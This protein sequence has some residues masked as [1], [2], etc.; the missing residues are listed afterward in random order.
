MQTDRKTSPSHYVL[1][2][3]AL[4]K[5]HIK[6]QRQYKQNCFS[7]FDDCNRQDVYGIRKISNKEASVFHIHFSEAVHII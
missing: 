6:G 2:L 4:S 1:I 7:H 5:E 3:C